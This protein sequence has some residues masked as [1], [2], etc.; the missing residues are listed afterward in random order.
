MRIKSIQAKHYT[1]TLY[2][3][4]KG[5]Q[6]EYESSNTGYRASEIILDYHSADFLFEIKLQELEGQ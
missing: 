5:Y 3:V 1:I 4:E 6:I 2:E